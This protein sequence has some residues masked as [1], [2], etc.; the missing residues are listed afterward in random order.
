MKLE[1]ITRVF[2]TGDPI[3]VNDL[4]KDEYKIIRIFNQHS[5][6][7]DGDCSYPMYVLGKVKQ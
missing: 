1:E 2:Q 7:S 5:T 6:T 3:K 4:L